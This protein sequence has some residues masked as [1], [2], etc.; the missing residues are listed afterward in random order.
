MLKDAVGKF[1][2]M[3]LRCGFD[4]YSYVVFHLPRELDISKMFLSCFVHDRKRNIVKRS[5]KDHRNLNLCEHAI[6]AKICSQD[7]PPLDNTATLKSR[8]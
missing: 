3:C 1:L 7:M 5:A 2:S 6:C 8:C 4:L